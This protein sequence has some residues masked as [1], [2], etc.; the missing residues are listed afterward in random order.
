MY[1]LAI[2]IQWEPLCVVCLAKLYW[3]SREIK[4][5][6]RIVRRR[7]ERAFDKNR[8]TMSITVEWFIYLSA[9]ISF[10]RRQR[11][12]NE[13]KNMFK[14]GANTSWIIQSDGEKRTKCWA[15]FSEE[16]R[17]SCALLWPG[18]TSSTLLSI[19]TQNV[20]NG[21]QLFMEFYRLDI[22]TC[23]QV[24]RLFLFDTPRSIN[25]CLECFT[26]WQAF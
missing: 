3:M 6:T 24:S 5:T 10:V 26:L 25:A 19:V 16:I 13:Q 23:L 15:S 14:S 22:I 18:P 8:I 2:A 17:W 7:R 9:V 20:F 21:S 4:E 12:D 1:A 11:Q